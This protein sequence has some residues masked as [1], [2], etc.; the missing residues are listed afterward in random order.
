MKKKIE[1]GIEINSYNPSEWT[2]DVHAEGFKADSDALR[3]L[4]EISEA[5]VEKVYEKIRKDL[6]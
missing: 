5:F 4:S 2:T 6:T 3:H 1:I